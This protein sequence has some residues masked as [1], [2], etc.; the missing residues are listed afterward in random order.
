MFIQGLC[1][2]LAPIRVLPELGKQGESSGSKPK[3][4]TSWYQDS[5]DTNFLN[6][7]GCNVANGVD[8]GDQPKQ[9]LV[10]MSF[11]S[12]VKLG[13]DSWGA[14]AFNQ[15]PVDT[16]QI[17]A[18]INAWGKGFFDC[19]NAGNRPQTDYRIAPG[20]TNQY[21]ADWGTVQASNHG[22]Q[23]ARMVSNIREYF[24]AQGYAGDVTAWGAV[25]MEIGYDGAI[26][27]RHWADGYQAVSGRPGYVNFGDAAGCEDFD[28]EGYGACGGPDDNWESTDVHYVSSKIPVA[29][30][31]PQIYRE[32]GVQAEQWVMISKYGYDTSNGIL[33]SKLH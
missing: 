5:V 30:P 3:T 20:V 16:G 33:P 14:S 23:W 22:D 21:P 15:D 12:P 28:A 26:V 1:L 7:K 13:T 18:A 11:G 19:L 24:E 31:L 9:G 17:R 4:T 27:S 29:L 32:D 10:I 25:D 8:Q 2:G 6:S